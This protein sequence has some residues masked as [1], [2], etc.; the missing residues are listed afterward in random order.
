MIPL[1]DNR[2]LWDLVRYQRM[3]LHDAELISDQEYADLASDHGSVK[4]LETYESLRRD[5]ASAKALLGEARF[6]VE[7]NCGLG[8]DVSP[9]LARIDALSPTPPAERTDK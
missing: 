2:R 6:Y 3:E 4:R 9:L 7:N 8:P 5:L 1:H